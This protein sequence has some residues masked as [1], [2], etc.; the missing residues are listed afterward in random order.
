MDAVIKTHTRYGNVT[1]RENRTK[2][3]TNGFTKS[4]VNFINKLADT[5]AMTDKTVFESKDWP[6]LWHKK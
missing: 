1:V 4:I 2:G 3:S 5:P 6:Y